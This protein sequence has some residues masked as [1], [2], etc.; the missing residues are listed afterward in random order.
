MNG[1]VVPTENPEVAGEKLLASMLAGTAIHAKT[2]NKLRQAI[3]HID[4]AK[5]QVALA[6]AAA[7]QS[8]LRAK[9]APRPHEI[10]NPAFVELFEAHQ[11]DRE[12]LFA[13]MRALENARSAVE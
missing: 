13:A 5:Q 11:R 10:S 1:R 6:R 3:S 7:D 2:S 4:A 8:L 12:V 9:S